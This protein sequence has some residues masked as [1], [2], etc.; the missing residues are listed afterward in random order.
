MRMINSAT[1]QLSS[2][3]GAAMQTLL[4]DAIAEQLCCLMHAMA[5]LALQCSPSE[6]FVLGCVLCCSPCCAAPLHSLQVWRC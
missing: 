3:L 4:R 2:G 1:S 5:P 6:G